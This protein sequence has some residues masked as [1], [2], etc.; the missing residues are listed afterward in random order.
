[1]NAREIL[2]AEIVAMHAAGGDG[3]KIASAL[4]AIDA[5][6]ASFIALNDIQCDDWADQNAQL[7]ECA[8]A[9]GYSPE[10]PRD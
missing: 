6:L 8:A 3:E 7:L 9:L 4:R 5:L 2:E 10:A 1:M